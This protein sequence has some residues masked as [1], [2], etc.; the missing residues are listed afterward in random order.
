MRAAITVFGNGA[1]NGGDRRVWLVTAESP[2]IGKGHVSLEPTLSDLHGRFFEYLRLSV[3]DVCNFRCTYC[4]PN[5]YQKSESR[6][7]NPEDTALSL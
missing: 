4:L 3:T 7:P 2:V 5:G 6:Y 1:A